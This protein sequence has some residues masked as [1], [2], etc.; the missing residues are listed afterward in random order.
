MHTIT[1]VYPHLIDIGC[2]SHTIDLVG[3][4]FM[5][6]N[7]DEFGKAWV[8]VFSHRERTG[9]SMATY[10]ET[11]W[12]SRWEVL[13]RLCCTSVILNLFSVKMRLHQLEGER[14]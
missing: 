12:W 5:T 6:P 3:E 9:R 1:V 13:N 7:L 11:R 14:C 8:G 2:Y 10:S 4:K